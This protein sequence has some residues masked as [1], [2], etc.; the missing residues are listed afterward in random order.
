MKLCAL[1]IDG[2]LFTATAGEWTVMAM[3]C[4]SLALRYAHGMMHGKVKTGAFTGAS[5]VQSIQ[6]RTIQYNL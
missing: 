6:N 1:F 2:F 4:F 3:V 5:S